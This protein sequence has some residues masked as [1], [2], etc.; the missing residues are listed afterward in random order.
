MSTR[1]VADSDG[2]VHEYF[3]HHESPHAAFAAHMRAIR[4]LGERI[5]SAL[6]G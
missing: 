4:G 2:D 1:F 6:A 3:S 5:R